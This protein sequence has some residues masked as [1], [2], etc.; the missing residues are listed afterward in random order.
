MNKN[1]VPERDEKLRQGECEDINIDNVGKR[2][3][4]K[5]KTEEDIM[6]LYYVGNNLVT[7]ICIISRDGIV[8]KKKS[9]KHLLMSNL[10]K[11]LSVAHTSW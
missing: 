7:N 5:T 1:E 8:R 10:Q 6:Y 2:D 3:L 9:N 11:Y 4:I